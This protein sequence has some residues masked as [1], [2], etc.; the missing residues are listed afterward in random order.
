MRRKTRIALAVLFAS[1]STL[2]VFHFITEAQAWL[3]W[4]ALA[5]AVGVVMLDAV[6]RRLEMWFDRRRRG[7][8]E[9]DSA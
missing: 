5:G 3:C 8:G 4:A 2:S 6:I 9:S 7:R 1:Y